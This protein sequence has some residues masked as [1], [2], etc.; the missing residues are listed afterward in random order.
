MSNHNQS[1]YFYD[2]N[3][4]FSEE[5]EKNKKLEIEKNKKLENELTNLK[6]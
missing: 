2:E 6:N 1:S 4:L 3:L 5:I